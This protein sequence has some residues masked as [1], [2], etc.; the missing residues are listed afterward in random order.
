[1]TSIDD[2]VEEYASLISE[3]I[4]LEARIKEIIARVTE[5]EKPILDNWLDRGISKLTITTKD[6]KRTI[7]IS[8]KFVCQKRGGVPKEDICDL[9]RSHGLEFLVNPS[10]EPSALKSQIREWY[11]EDPESIPKDLKEKLYIEEIPLLRTTKS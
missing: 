10:Y 4:D 7:F 3:R 6:A 2:K 1:M 5:I 8:T 9:L 11:E